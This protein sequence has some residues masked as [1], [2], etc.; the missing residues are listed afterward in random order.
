MSEVISRHPRVLTFTALITASFTESGLIFSTKTL[1]MMNIVG[2]GTCLPGYLK[3]T[4]QAVASGLKPAAVAVPVTKEAPVYVHPSSTVS[5]GLQDNVPSGWISARSSL[6][7]MYVPR[8]SD[9][10]A[11]PRDTSQIDYFL[12][13]ITTHCDCSSAPAVAQTGRPST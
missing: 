7:G 3:A 9:V 6:T 13:Y 5:C 8:L 4:S 12:S 2:R 1:V 11:D 10:T